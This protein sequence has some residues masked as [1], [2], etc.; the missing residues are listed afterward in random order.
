[1]K[2]PEL[3]SDF[4]LLDDM[5][6]AEHPAH[7]AFVK[8]MKG[9]AYGRGALNSAWLWFR[10]GWDNRPPYE[11]RSLLDALR[12]LS[13]DITSGHIKPAE[14][15][16]RDGAGPPTPMETRT[17]EDGTKYQ[18]NGEG[19]LLWRGSVSGARA[20]LA[21]AERALKPDPAV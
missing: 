10:D 13:D 14:W 11:L 2:S 7:A 4:Y 6:F 16:A 5:R 9:R 12:V 1:M 18:T 3:A 21:V 20:M 19:Y 17:T 15:A 8:A